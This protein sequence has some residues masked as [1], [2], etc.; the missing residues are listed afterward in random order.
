MAE[1]GNGRITAAEHDIDAIQE[2]LGDI[3]DGMGELRR[4]QQDTREQLSL[5]RQGLTDLTRE[6]RDGTAQARQT[7]AAHE[8]RIRVLE[9][10]AKAQHR[11]IIQRA[12]A[13]KASRWRLLA[14]VVTALVGAAEILAGWL[15]AG[16][17]HP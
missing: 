4:G 13:A 8:E 10:E 14:P 16:A 7:Q 5:L 1:E 15:H 11:A 2:T 12:G 6:V 9:R 3:R 17:Q